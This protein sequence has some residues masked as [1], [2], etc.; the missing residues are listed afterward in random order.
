VYTQVH[1]VFCSVVLLDSRINLTYVVTTYLSIRDELTNKQHSWVENVKISFLIISQI[2]MLTDCV[3]KP[4]STVYCIRVWTKRPTLAQAI[5][6]INI[7]FIQTH[8]RYLSRPI[9]CSQLIVDLTYPFTR[10]LLRDATITYRP[11]EYIWTSIYR[12]TER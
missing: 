7:I 2:L 12:P 11:S 1:F 8:N 9:C 6:G 5:Y 10:S 4:H 3:Y